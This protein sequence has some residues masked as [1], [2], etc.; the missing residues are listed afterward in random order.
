MEV[1]LI[2]IW[3][4]SI[5]ELRG[6]RK[7]KTGNLYARNN[8]M[9]IHST[10]LFLAGRKKIKWGQAVALLPRGSIISWSTRF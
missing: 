10:I 5:E 2:D 6:A 9:E 7:T 3:Q 4:E 1:L 8:I